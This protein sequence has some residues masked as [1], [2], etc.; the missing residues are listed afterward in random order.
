MIADD[1]SLH[2]LNH[3]ALPAIVC[4]W[5]AACSWGTLAFWRYEAT[6]GQSGSVQKHWPE[7]SLLPRRA[8]QSSLTMFAH[9]HCPC[10]RASLNE[11]ANI[12]ADQPRFGSIRVVFSV[13]VDATPEWFD[14]EVV[15]LAKS[16][17]GVEIVFDDGGRISTRFGA[18]TSGH[19]LLYDAAG[20]LKFSGGITGL[21]GHEGP[22]RGRT[23][24]TA[25]GQNPRGP[26]QA[27]VVFGC[28]LVGTASQTCHVNAGNSP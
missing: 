6:A 3:R 24:V 22:N 7:S 5:L 17:K 26:A 13:P 21:R 8:N 20:D 14:T 28:A 18:Q 2:F 23:T 10:T 27:S 12:L 16:M 4:F 9:P 25:L 11:L 1:M 19:T 15:R